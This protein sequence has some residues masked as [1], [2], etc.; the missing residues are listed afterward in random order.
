MEL[1]SE[2]SDDSSVSTIHHKLGSLHYDQ[3][4][5]KQAINHLQSCI[6]SF[7]ENESEEDRL[8]LATKMLCSAF[9]KIED[10][11]T[12]L[13][14]YDELA[15]LL[16]SRKYSRDDEISEVLLSQGYILV[17]SSDDDE[18]L[19]IFQKSLHLKRNCRFPDEIGIARLLKVMAEVNF[20]QN[21]FKIAAELL[22]E[23]SLL[24][25]IPVLS[26]L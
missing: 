5:Y 7:Q 6:K 13:L 14:T 26:D 24:Y 11:P 22:R 3:G 19:N 25:S 16:K 9:E 17:K 15:C 2:V 23:V 18:A 4:Q 20:R 8:V 21:N 1:Y 10:F 12:A